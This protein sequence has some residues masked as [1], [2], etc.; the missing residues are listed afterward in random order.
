VIKKQWSL[1]LFLAYL[2]LLM[3][4]IDLDWLSNL[5][6]LPLDFVFMAQVYAI[7]KKKYA[8][9]RIKLMSSHWRNEL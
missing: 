8:K 3:A 7:I 6:L 9:L 2:G 4:E 1:L 5:A